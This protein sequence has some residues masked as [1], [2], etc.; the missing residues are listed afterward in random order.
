MQD[1]SENISDTPPLK[2]KTKLICGLN[3]QL[4]VHRWGKKGYIQ[5]TEYVKKARNKWNGHTSCIQSELGH[6]RH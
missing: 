6:A 2:P 1:R 3:E 5:C 4:K